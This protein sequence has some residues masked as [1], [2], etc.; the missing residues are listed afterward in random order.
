MIALFDQEYAVD[1]ALRAQAKKSEILGAIR[2]YRE[3]F[4]YDDETIIHN[5]M[6]KFAISREEAEEYVLPG[7]ATFRQQKI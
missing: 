6:K 3:D 1:Q 7:V 2:V 4:E 5:I